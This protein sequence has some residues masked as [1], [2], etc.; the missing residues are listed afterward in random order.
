MPDYNIYIHS[1][2]SGDGDGNATKPKTDKDSK[3]KPKTAQK[4]AKGIGLL[5]NPDSL[6]S[7]GIG[8]A[9]KEVSKAVPAVAVAY[10]VLKVS[11]RMIT[12]TQ[13]FQVA[14]TG[15]YSSQIAYSNFKQGIKNALTPFS[16]S[17]NLALARHNA[18]IEQQRVNQQISLLGESVINQGYV[19]KGV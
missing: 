9:A 16:T 15:D 14:S 10:A 4:I 6:I 12:I 11:D 3:T 8:I 19:R 7:E 2:G 13:Q 18:K 1:V 17:L 5:S